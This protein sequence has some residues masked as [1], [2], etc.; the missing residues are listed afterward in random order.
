[1]YVYPDLNFVIKAEQITKMETA[2]HVGA[3]KALRNQ[4]PEFHLLFTT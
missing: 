3:A 1:M 2:K 4:P